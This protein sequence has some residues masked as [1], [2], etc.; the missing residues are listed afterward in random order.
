LLFF[1]KFQNL[2]GFFDGSTKV[3]GASPSTHIGCEWCVH[4]ASFKHALNRTHD[5]LPSLCITEMLEHHGAT[6]DL[7]DRI[8]NTLARDV[9]R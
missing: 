2:Q 5:R 1:Y 8:C 4:G 3:S 7:S 6:P 9:R